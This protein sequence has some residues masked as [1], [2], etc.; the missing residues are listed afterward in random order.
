MKT[1]RTQCGI[2]GIDAGSGPILHLLAIVLVAGMPPASLGAPRVV[3]SSVPEGGIA[4]ISNLSLRVTVQFDEKV[5]PVT[6]PSAIPLVTHGGKAALPSQFSVSH[7]GLELTALFQGVKE[8]D[9]V[10]T[11]A[12]GRVRGIS[13]E[14]LDGDGDG[15]PGGDYALSF[16][17]DSTVRP[18]P[19]P[20][21]PRVPPGSLVHDPFFS[22]KIFPK[23][24]ADSYV[25]G[26]GTGQ[27]LSVVVESSETVK[28]KISVRNPADS[29]IGTSVP[30]AHGSGALIQALSIPTSGFYR[31]T[32]SGIGTNTGNYNV[33]ITL[34]AAVEEE[35]LTGLPNDM[36]SVA[37]SI[38]LSFIPLPGGLRRAAVVG[39]LPKPEAVP[40]E[41][42]GDQGIESTLSSSSTPET[43]PADRYSFTLNAGAYVSLALDSEFRQASGLSLLASDGSILVEGTNAAHLAAWIGPT[44][45]PSTGTYR[46]TVEGTAGR[47]TLVV[48]ENGQFEIES[49]NGVQE[50]RYIG[51]HGRVLGAVDDATGADHFLVGLARGDGLTI[52]THTPFAGPFEF[53]NSLD[54]AIELYD[55]SGQLVHLETG[56]A[57]DGKNAVLHHF[58]EHYGPYRIRI[59]SEQSAGEYLLVSDVLDRRVDKDGDGLPDAWEQKYGLNPNDNGTINWIDGALGD[60]DKDGAPNRAERTAGTNPNNSTSVF[61]IVDVSQ[62]SVSNDLAITFATQPAIRYAIEYVDSYPTNQSAPVWTGFS[63]SRDGVGT[64]FE[65][66]TEAGTYTFVDDFSEATSGGNPQNGRRHYRVHIPSLAIFADP[67]FVHYDKEAGIASEGIN[68]E[69]A[70][71]AL[72]YAVNPFSGVSAGAFSAGIAATDTLV[73]PELER[74]SLAPVLSSGAISTISNFVANGGTI[75]IHSQ[76]SDHDE[77]FINTVF[78]LNLAPGLEASGSASSLKTQATAGTMFENSRSPLPNNDGIRTWLTSS[79]PETAQHSLYE[80]ENTGIDFTSVA[81]IPF[82]RGKIVFLAWDWYDGVPIGSQ[83]GGWLE[84]LEAATLEGLKP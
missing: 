44:A 74:Q 54:P 23:G 5:A 72:G 84:I 39:K 77:E 64:W 31:I 1:A 19:I 4:T 17:V 73:I 43:D 63:N 42:P 37:E 56:S 55:P 57:P 33:D 60:P 46:A 49:N 25:V 10:F 80:F 36:V 75:L 32:I 51:Q 12:N 76:F 28:P 71:V 3:G 83:D 79:L 16:T 35:G 47:Y 7:T 21:I 50:A 20:L 67:N 2:P 81:M 53:Q 15:T 78:G 29:L 30:G 27:L 13:G 65:T 24:D 14:E 38:D 9:Y 69:A 11:L 40:P 8:G 48:V 61:A 45:I 70:L 66:N 52:E 68:L 18:L 62:G 58:A 22:A 6:D 59:F 82:G 26:L 34:N 41:I